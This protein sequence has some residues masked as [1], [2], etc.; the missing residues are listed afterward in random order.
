MNLSSIWGILIKPFKL[1]SKIKLSKIGKLTSLSLTLIIGTLISVFFF[2]S[3]IGTDNT[4]VTESQ[5]I[6]TMQKG[7]LVSDVTI[8]GQ[9]KFSDKDELKFLSSG[10]IAKISIEENQLVKSGSVLAELDDI[11]TTELAKNVAKANSDVATAKYSLKL[12]ESNLVDLSLIHI[13]EPT[14]P[15]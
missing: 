15:Y 5:Q 6:I 8:T 14:R 9:I 11:K 10:K 4:I 13:S 3:Y 2:K 12:S 7:D 1:I